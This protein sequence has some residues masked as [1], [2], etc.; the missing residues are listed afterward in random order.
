DRIRETLTIRREVSV[1]GYASCDTHVHSLTHSGHGDATE[2]ERVIAIAGEGLELPIATEH[3]KQVDYHAAAV[4]AGVRSYFTPIVGDEVTKPVGHVNIFPVKPAGP[5]PDDK[6]KDWA[7]LFKE[8][9]RTQAPVR[10]LNHPRD[11]H[12]GFRPFGPEH[13]I[14]VTGEN[15]DSWD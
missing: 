6:V 9:D 14:A 10:I 11:V 3:N 15:L 8:I 12:L 5:V 13:H 1:P 7:G 2:T 4:K